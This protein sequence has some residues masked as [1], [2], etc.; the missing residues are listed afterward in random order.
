MRFI[1]VP[2]IIKR[3]LSNY[4]W[5]LPTAD[6]KIYLTFYDGPTPEIT[7]WTLDLLKK[8]NAK[9]TFFCIGDNI[10]KYTEIFKEL[11]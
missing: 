10:K 11:I 5:D 8:Y 1:K 6:K 4:V 9:A 2:Q 7:Q 3:L